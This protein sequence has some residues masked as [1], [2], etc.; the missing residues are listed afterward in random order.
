[1]TLARDAGDSGNVVCFQGMTHTHQK[2][3]REYGEDQIGRSAE[4]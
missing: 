2:T 4:P 3:K 1:L